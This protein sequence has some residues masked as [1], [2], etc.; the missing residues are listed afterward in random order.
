MA[1]LSML[2]TAGVLLCTCFGYVVHIVYNH[3][4][5]INELRKQGVPMPKEWSWITGHLL[6]LQKYVDQ[7]P[8]DAAVAF[9]M[10]DLCKEHADTELFLMDFWPVYPPLFTVFGPGPISQICNKYNLP[11]TAVSSRFMQP[12]T[13]G[14]N[15]IS[16]N[17]DEWKYW[18]SLFNPGFST[19]AMLNNV[20]HIVDSVLVFR[21]KLIQMV[22]K[23][24]F[25]LD[26]LTTRLTMEII[27]KVTLYNGHVMNKYIRQELERRFQETKT[28]HA[29]GAD[30]T[31]RKP[32]SIKS[33]TTLALEAYMAETP[34]VDI[35][36]ND[37]LDERF[38]HYATCQIRLFLFA[39]TD[40]T[41]TIIVYI[42]HMLAKHPEWL[43]K[44][45][46]EHNEVF[47]KD[48]DVA[49]S[50]LK[51]NPSLLNNC[52]LTVAFI[53]EVLRIYG[54][55]GTLRSGLPGF[56]VTDHQGNEQPMEY[57]GANVLHQALHTNSRVWPRANEFLPER[58]LV[59]SEDELHADP[60]AY[61][62][63]EQ[64]PRNCIG[65]TLVW[66][67]L[68]VVVILTCRDLEIRDAYDDFD[69]KMESEMGVVE[70]MKRTLFGQPIKTV[71][72]E[73]AYQTDSGGLHPANGY[74]C[75]VKWA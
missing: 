11:K 58:F 71:H 50:A 17:G 40:T 37:K 57:A 4:R 38:A 36:H 5:K 44:L 67:E 41:S 26:E 53:K 3:R 15:L 22:E 61:R 10:R 73:R 52:K 74:P 20:P 24:M 51:E 35:L 47:G 23:G 14:P 30:G 2:S 75:Y 9:A 69:A 29:V 72:G 49:A 7:I 59:G 21:E 60:A 33:V 68:R 56:T 62:P 46:N 34:E 18:R 28:A 42:Y 13:G 66:N 27:L 48:P 45:R 12:I 32:K 19:G 55:A 65:Q 6:V 31:Q 16:M 43:R 25:S 1:W 54:P 8:P 70:K 39:G 63:F 64:G